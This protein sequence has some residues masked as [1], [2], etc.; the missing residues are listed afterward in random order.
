MFW[1]LSPAQHGPVPSNHSTIGGLASAAAASSPHSPPPTAQTAVRELL[2]NWSELASP[3]FI[4]Q[5]WTLAKQQQNIK[6]HK[7]KRRQFLSLLAVSPPLFFFFHSLVLDPTNPRLYLAHSQSS[8][9][10]G[11]FFFF[12]VLQLGLLAASCSEINQGLS[13]HLLTSSSLRNASA[14]C[15]GRPHP[16]VQMPKKHRAVWIRCEEEKEKKIE[17]D[18]V[19][20]IWKQSAF[21]QAEQKKE[22]MET[23]GKEGKQG[24]GH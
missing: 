23:D 16:K 5:P 18:E 13:S 17:H 24:W 19:W 20:W 14:V 10:E 22:G 12:F 3:Q 6:A 11:F 4:A 2:T 21:V 1:R 9:G 8:V 15:S 7:R